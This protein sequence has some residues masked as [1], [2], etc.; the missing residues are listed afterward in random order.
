MKSAITKGVLVLLAILGTILCVWEA[1]RTSSIDLL[2]PVVTLAIIVVL[3][4]WNDDNWEEYSNITALAVC[5]VMLSWPITVKYGL[6]LGLATWALGISVWL[7]KML[8]SFRK[9]SICIVAVSR[10]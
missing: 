3:S 4:I 5:I 8:K 10:P 6:F 9:L 7:S 2:A 1:A